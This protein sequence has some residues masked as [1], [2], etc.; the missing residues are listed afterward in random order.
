MKYAVLLKLNAFLLNCRHERLCAYGSAECYIQ[1]LW[2]CEKKYQCLVLYTVSQKNRTHI[3]WS[4]TLTNIDQYQC[5]LT[6]LFLQ[7][8]LI[9]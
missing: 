9:I 7:H 5:H 8:Y 6:E 2:Y 1:T 3:L 4:I